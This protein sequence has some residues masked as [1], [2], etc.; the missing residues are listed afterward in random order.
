MLMG[1]LFRDIISEARYIGNHT[2]AVQRGLNI[3]ITLFIISEK[4]FFA[5]FS[6]PN[7]TA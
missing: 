4:F 2:L 6:T 3:G 7:L 5:I 1:L